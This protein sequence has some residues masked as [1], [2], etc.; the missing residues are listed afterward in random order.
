[1]LAMKAAGELWAT[2]I[3]FLVI[4]TETGLLKRAAPKHVKMKTFFVACSL[5]I[6]LLISATGVST[7]H[8]E[9]WSFVEGLYSWFITFT[10]IGFGDYVHLKS[11]GRKVEHG[12]TSKTRLVFYAILFELPSVVGLSLMSCILTCLVD[13]MDQLRDLRDRFTNC[14]P[15]F[16]CLARR[17][18]SSRVTVIKDFKQED[19]QAYEISEAIG[20][21]VCK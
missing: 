14:C 21:E 15:T 9:D 18:H 11:L 5:I 10:T 6:V 12:E 8:L 7:N 19:N 4:K 3:R 13:S 20:S 2:C 16:N 1:M 17:L